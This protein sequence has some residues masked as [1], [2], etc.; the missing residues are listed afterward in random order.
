M[1]S[2]DPEHDD[3]KARG[4]AS[5]ARRL[6][7][8]AG[9]TATL[10]GRY[11]G[12]AIA[13]GF[14]SADE[15][16]HARGKLN[17]SAAAHLAETLGE[18]KGAVMKLGQVASQAASILPAEFAEPLKRLQKDAP[19]M[20]FAVIRKQID[21]DLGKEKARQLIKRIEHKP[22]AAASIGQVHRAVLHDGREVVIK[23]Q[24]PGV[25]ESCDTDLGQLK[26]ALR[27]ARI[28]KVD[29][30]TLDDLFEE[31]RARLHEELDYEQ[32]AR[33][34]DLF[35]RFF[36]DDPRLVI[37]QTV[38]ELCSKHVLTMLLEPGDRLDEAPKSY[39]QALRNE[40]AVRLFDFMCRSV[41]ELKAVHADPH[42]G[43]FAIRRDGSLVVYDF[44]CVKQLERESVDAYRDTVRAAI[45]RDWRAVDRGLMRLGVRVP[46]SRPVSDEFYASWDKIVMRPFRGDAPYDFGAS[47][48]HVEAIAK[49]YEALEHLD[50]FRPPVKTAYLDRMV[51]G[52]YWT[53]TTLKA[54]VALGPRLKRFLG[55]SS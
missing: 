46:D 16:A 33:N 21:C 39:E 44:G 5:G 29:K 34:I 42:P 45:A 55:E 51:G 4:P 18:L 1:T 35:R 26:L 3:D 19:P 9:M 41:F 40:I 37:P 47:T 54:R 7:K 24:Y 23:V 12:H 36:A 8:L 15:R 48:M 53:M 22:Y 49:G 31:I 20:P 11:A 28:V 13:N 17:A 38:P 2:D 52:H 32:E 10:A 27:M 43:N 30:A 14:R 6:L 25:A 50:Q